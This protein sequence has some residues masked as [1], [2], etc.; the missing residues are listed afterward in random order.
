MHGILQ[1]IHI[2][3]IARPVFRECLLR[4]YF[5]QPDRSLSGTNAAALAPRRLVPR[6]SLPDIPLLFL[7]PLTLPSHCSGLSPRATLRVRKCTTEL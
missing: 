2:H 3:N 1:N 4:A 7:Y 6:L 5:K